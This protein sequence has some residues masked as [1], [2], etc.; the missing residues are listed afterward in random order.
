MASTVQYWQNTQKMRFISPGGTTYVLSKNPT[1]LPMIPLTKAKADVPIAPAPNLLN[2][3]SEFSAAAIPMEW[4][5]MDYQEYL[6]LQQ[7]HLQPCTMISPDDNG[8][9]GW[10][11][12]GQFDYLPGVQ[13]KVGA[14]KAAFIVSTPANGL[15]TVISTL[16][17]P[18]AGN[19]TATQTTGGS[20]ASGTTLYYVMTFYSNWGQTL[21]SPV[22]SA[23]TS[24]SGA[25]INLA[26]TAPTSAYFRRARLYIS[27]SNNFVAGNAAFVKADIYS[28]WNQTWIDYCGTSGVTSTDTLPLTNTA[29]TGSWRGGLFVSAS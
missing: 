20:I 25:A 24:A 27:T 15:N 29:Y 8:F 1:K 18:V 19:L 28:A 2:G 26:W 13:T 3:G 9:Y 4:P 10:L 22:V 17:N 12:L 16:A 11:S 5:E 23:T 6:N 21:M 14:V 7:F